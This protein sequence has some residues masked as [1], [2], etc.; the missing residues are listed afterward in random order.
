MVERRPMPA[1]DVVVVGAG[2]AGLSATIGLVERGASVHVVA[3]GMAA[4][5]WVHGGLDVA[6]PSG[7]LSA[8]E[9]VE[10]LRQRPGHPYAL[11]HADVIASVERTTARLASV[12]LGYVG[13]PG[14][15]LRQVPTAVGGLR[16]AAIL[17]A[18][19]AAAALPWEPDEGL[20]LVGFERFRDFWPAYAARNL[21]LQA[22]PD[23]PARFHAAIARLP[24]VDRLH[25]LN[26]LVLA[27]RFDDAAWR[28]RALGAIA[29]VIPRAGRW[30]IAVPA[31]LGLARHAEVLE[32]VVEALG[33]PVFEVP[34]LPPSVPGLRL[35]EALRDRARAS[36]ATIQ[37]GFEVS[38]V[39]RQGDRIVAVE[40]R[41]AA[42]PLRLRARDL[43]LATGGIAAGGFRA[44]RDGV[45]REP[46]L[47][48]PVQAPSREAWL[49]GDLYGAAGVELEAAGV[50]VDANLRP[51]GRD[52]TPL[53]ENV[54]VAGSA[55]AG[56]R[57]LSERCGDGVALASAWRA[58]RE[59]SGDA[60]GAV[61]VA[62]AGGHDR[63]PDGQP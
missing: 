37:I 13:D 50:R 53:F 23:G 16:P 27:R 49:S 4:T 58:T 55:L 56:M 42:R 11:L 2:L 41:A 52:G 35:F 57:Y 54:R 7:A 30:R 25:N 28:T 6:A 20:L 1:A 15:T 24:D 32:S 3:T 59:I 36:G 62:G 10:M 34:T 22:W 39:E 17:P 12:G 48:L 46:I 51:L 26:S 21:A 5:H 14:S 44:G 29:Q 33:H 38:G 43:L 19:Q 47:D 9:G 61:G 60:P 31:V 18:G 63:G 40:T 45:V 8:L